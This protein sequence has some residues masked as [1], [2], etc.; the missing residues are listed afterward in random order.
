MQKDKHA[1]AA[2]AL[3]KAIQDIKDIYNEPADEMHLLRIRQ[4]LQTAHNYVS[5][6]G[7]QDVF[8]DR[9]ES[10]PPATSI[11]GEKI[12]RPVYPTKS[13]LQADKKAV[14]V[15]RDKVEALYPEFL[16]LTADYIAKSVEDNVVRGV[17]KKAG[18]K[19]SKNEPKTIHTEFVEQI[20]DAI[21]KKGADTE[22]AV[23]QIKAKIAAGGLSLEDYTEY[24]RILVH[25][26]PDE[27]EGLIDPEAWA[28]A[29]PIA[30]Q[31]TETDG[32]N[33]N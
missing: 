14:D 29:T 15:L 23:E 7:G 9:V 10:L 25:I 30:K 4:P 19:V 13:D 12:T 27:A 26:A 18:M 17:A 32:N 16:Y 1:R 11:G 21:I 31:N 24:Y 5:L 22:K 20:K 8:L 2:Q 6:I 3:Q 33:A 28:A